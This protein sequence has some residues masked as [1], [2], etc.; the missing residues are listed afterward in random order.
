MSPTSQSE[1]S[2]KTNVDFCKFW[3]PIVSGI[4]DTTVDQRVCSWL[5]VYLSLLEAKRQDCIDEGRH[6]VFSRRIQRAVLGVK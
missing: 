6:L 2:V 4:W 1:S 5:G 3:A